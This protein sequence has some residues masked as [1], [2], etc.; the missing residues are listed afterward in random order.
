[1]K[2]LLV[3]AILIT[4]STSNAKDKACPLMVE[5]EIDPEESVTV[6]GREIEFCCGTCVR[7]FEENKA[8][9]IK[10]VKYLNEIF[11]PDQ[12]KKLGVNDVVL[13]Q[14]RR[15]P[16][17][18]DRIINPN[19]PTVEYKDMKI[20]FW[21]SSAVRRWNRDPEKYYQAAKAAGILK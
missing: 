3:A 20:Y 15:C 17:Y 16:I 8:Y 19:S 12:R 5:D 18:P 21:S 14:Q 6:E 4:T 9:Y 7:K 11:T 13:L 10:A 2:L 1:M